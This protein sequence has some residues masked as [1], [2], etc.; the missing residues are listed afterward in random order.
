VCAFALPRLRLVREDVLPLLVEEN[1]FFVQREAAKVAQRAFTLGVPVERVLVGDLF[2]AAVCSV[3]VESSS[4]SAIHVSHVLRNFS[5]ERVA[6]LFEIAIVLQRNVARI[7][8]HHIGIVIHARRYF[9]RRW[10]V[11]LEVFY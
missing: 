2:K 3:V 4:Q 9:L 8:T 11:A 7:N 6:Q 1:A 5:E 10:H